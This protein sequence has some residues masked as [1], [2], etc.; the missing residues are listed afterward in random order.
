[1][2]RWYRRASLGE[3]IRL[4]AN[5]WLEYSGVPRA[6]LISIVISPRKPRPIAKDDQIADL[7]CLI[8]PDSET[9]RDE[10]TAP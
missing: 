10:D 5:Q 3:V 4:W 9:S 8:S 7:F 1:M 6:H 2:L